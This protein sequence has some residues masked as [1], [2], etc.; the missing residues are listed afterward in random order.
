MVTDK[1]AAQVLELLAD[2][3]SL[4]AACRKVEIS[5]AKDILDLVDHDEAYAAHYAHARERGYTM[6]GEDLLQVSDDDTIEPNSRRIMVDT[7]KWMLAKMLPKRFGEKLELSGKLT[8]G[9]DAMSDAELAA[10][11]ATKPRE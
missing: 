5:R 10:I 1:Q 9:P 8:T 6:L 11:A 4:R 2:G 3:M 7:R